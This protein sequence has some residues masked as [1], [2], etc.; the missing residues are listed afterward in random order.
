MTIDRLSPGSS[1]TAYPPPEKWDDHREY[2]PKMWPRRVE[3]RERRRGRERAVLR[4]QALVLPELG[5]ERRHLRQVR[6]VRVA[7]L[8]RVGD[9]VHVAQRAPGA[10]QAVE[11]VGDGLG[12]AVPRRLARVG[13]DALDW[14]PLGL[15]DRRIIT[16]TDNHKGRGRRNSQT[17]TLDQRALSNICDCLS[18]SPHP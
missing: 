10:M 6:V 1:L 9:R 17:Y 7:Q 8:G 15:D 3:R 18:Q 16:D 11:R 2:D 14:A 13:H 12:D 5:V 4:V